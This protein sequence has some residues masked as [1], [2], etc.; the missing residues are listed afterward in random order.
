[1]AKQR[2]VLEEPLFCATNRQSPHSDALPFDHD[3]AALPNRFG[4]GREIG[5]QELQLN[6]GPLGSAPK[7]DHR[8]PNFFLQGQEAGKV[9]VG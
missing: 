5:E 6:R 7:K 3:D 9:R 4:N 8:W 1:M 2:D